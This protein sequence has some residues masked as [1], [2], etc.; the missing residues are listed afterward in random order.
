M[1]TTNQFHTLAFMNDSTFNVAILLIAISLF[2]LVLVGMDL[3]GQLVSRAYEYIAS[4]EHRLR[5]LRKR[6]FAGKPHA[7]INPQKVL[8]RS[9]SPKA[10]VNHDRIPTNKQTPAPARLRA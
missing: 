8:R 3:A 2:A 4:G 5:R 10:F 7:R 1:N 6:N 9:A